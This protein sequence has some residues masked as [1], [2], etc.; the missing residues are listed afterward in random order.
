MSVDNSSP[1]NDVIEKEKFYNFTITETKI[2]IDKETG[3]K[4]IQI[5]SFNVE[6]SRIETSE[7]FNLLIDTNQSS[8]NISTVYE[9][10]DNSN[11]S[12]YKNLNNY[13]YNFENLKTLIL[14]PYPNSINRMIGNEQLYP[15]WLSEENTGKNSSGL[16][17][18]DMNN[19]IG[20]PIQTNNNSYFGVNTDKEITDIILIYN[21]ILDQFINDDKKT[22]RIDI[23]SNAF[24]K[25][26]NLKNVYIYGIPN[27]Y[28]VNAD[29][30]NYYLFHEDV[31]SRDIKNCN[32]INFYFIKPNDITD[33]EYARKIDT[34]LNINV[35]SN[36][37]NITNGCLLK[38]DYDDFIENKYKKE[39]DYINVVT[40]FD[41]ESGK[42]NKDSNSNNLKK[43]KKCLKNKCQISINSKF[44]EYLEEL[45]D[46]E[47]IYD[48]FEDDENDDNENNDDECNDDE[49]GNDGNG[50]ESLFEKLRKIFRFSVE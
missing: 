27:F 28:N 30:N 6:A 33:G 37:D 18:I 42:F 9:S 4:E 44:N 50:S 5:P 21:E 47:T 8:V 2:V 41:N 46:I 38:P 13:N 45:T 7:L 31:R 3:E 16:I 40:P 23:F 35:N 17:Y 15:L 49:T 14:C 12:V 43:L 1:I 26:P 36:S 10:F 29:N 22:R 19:S 34:F 39:K 20:L 48:V 32:K 25:Y 11:S 24:N